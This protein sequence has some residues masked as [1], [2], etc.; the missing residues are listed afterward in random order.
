MTDSALLV[1]AKDWA[2][3]ADAVKSSFP[4][5]AN[6]SVWEAPEAILA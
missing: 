2:A 1:A 6:I 4:T 5:E 3:G